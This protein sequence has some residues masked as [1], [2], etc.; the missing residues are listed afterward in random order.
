MTGLSLFLRIIWFASG[1]LQLGILVLIFSLRHYRT[2]PTFSW[3]IGLNLSQAIVLLIVYSHYGFLSGPSFHTYWGTQVVIMIVQTLASAE[4]LHRAL[5]D[6]PGIWELTWRL[7][8]CAV[9]VVIAY[10]WYTANRADEWGLLSADRGYYFTFAVAFISCLLLIRHYSVSIDP[11]YKIMLG[12][13]CFYSCGAFVADT[14]LKAQFLE[15]FPKY[16]EVWNE[17]EL[18]IF[19]TVLVVWVVAL[20]HSVAVPARPAPP[21]GGAYEVVGPQVNLELQKLNDTLR[22]F[23]RRQA[24]ES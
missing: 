18:L 16:S 1:V 15:H 17:S 3:Y 2:L 21:S 24:A 8:L 22:K 4:I 11:V 14:V 7:I 5:Q 23:F 13:F 20:R 9:I 6:Y 10:S 12:G 19:F